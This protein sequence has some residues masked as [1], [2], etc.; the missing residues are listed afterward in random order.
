[1][2]RRSETMIALPTE[3]VHSISA[4]VGSAEIELQF[5]QN[6]EFVKLL[7]KGASAEVHLIREKDSKKEFACKIVRKSSG[8]NDTKSMQTEAL[9]MKKLRDLHLLSM[10]EIYETNET[11]WMVLELADGGDLM[12]GLASLTVYNE[13]NIA[14]VF[15]QILLGVKYLHSNGIV[16][17]DLKMDNLLYSSVK[18]QSSSSSSSSQESPILVKIADFG[19]SALAS[20][21][22]NENNSQKLKNLKALTEM[23]GTMEYFAPEI[24]EKAYG[25]QVDIWALGCILFEMLTGE[26]AFPNR[27]LTPSMIEKMMSASGWKKTIRLFELR[28]GWKDLSPLAQSFIRG[29]LKR[30]PKKR[31]DIDECLSHPWIQNIENHH[32]DGQWYDKELIH[33]KKI[34][35]ERSQRRVR[36]YQNLLKDLEKDQ[37]R[38]AAVAKLL[39]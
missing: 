25:F 22:R 5:H 12:H 37:L 24:Y 2:R 27:E 23:W 35:S 38:A 7:G 34:I 6:Y 17:R 8:I 14:K 19:L 10:H 15:K 13:R 28:S 4:M 16:H 30:N 3:H 9:I 39:Q 33:A 32:I 20:V 21:K 11:I 1:M 36:R 26:I 31:F 18:S 29:M